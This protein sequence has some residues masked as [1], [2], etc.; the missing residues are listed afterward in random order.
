MLTTIPVASTDSFDT[1]GR[2]AVDG[3]PRLAV[4]A[5]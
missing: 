4:S 2:D 5:V 1:V 3:E